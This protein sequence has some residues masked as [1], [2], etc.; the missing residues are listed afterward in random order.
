VGDSQGHVELQAQGH[1]LEVSVKTPYSPK[2]TGTRG[3]VTE[4]SAESRMRLFKL[5]SR[6]KTPEKSGF[7][8]RLSFLTLTTR[9]FYHPRDFKEKLFEL[10]RIFSERFPDMAVV[11]RLEY[12]ERGAPHAHCILY[13]APFIPKDKLQAVWGEIVGQKEPFTRIELIRKYRGLMAYVSKYVGKEAAGFN[14]AAYLRANSLPSETKVDSPG[15][16]WG[17]WNRKALPFDRL[18]EDKIPL[19]GSIWMIRAYCAKFYDGVLDYPGQGFTI[20]MDDP[21]SALNYCRK[22]SRDFL[23]AKSALDF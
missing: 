6:L 9:R 23:K 1:L 14:I 20:F 8:S 5:L 2:G 10:F 7:R 21:Y 17:V 13:N 18:E 22:L 19:D 16:V 12:Q 11:W 4:F 15:R 3:G